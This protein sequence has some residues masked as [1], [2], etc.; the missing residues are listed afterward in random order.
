MFFPLLQRIIRGHK[1]YAYLTPKGLAKPKS[2][3]TTLYYA[4]CEQWASYCSS[5]AKEICGYKVQGTW[6]SAILRGG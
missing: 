5:L 1:P 3:P 4:L 2:G 6:T